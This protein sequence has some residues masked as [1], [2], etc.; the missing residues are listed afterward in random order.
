MPVLKSQ[1][2]VLELLFLLL[3]TPP[4]LNIMFSLPVLLAPWQ[5]SILGTLHNM[6]Y[7]VE[8]ARQKSDSAD[9]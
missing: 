6:S 1:L 5:R 3:Q 8:A 9:H 2:I 4:S 7:N